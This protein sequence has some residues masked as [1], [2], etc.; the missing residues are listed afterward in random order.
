MNTAEKVPN[1]SSTFI[2]TYV[3]HVQV[4]CL[5]LAPQNLHA[6][7]S[8][9]ITTASLSS[10]SGASRFTEVQQQHKSSGIAARLATAAEVV[11]VA[12]KCNTCL[13]QKRAWQPLLGLNI[14]RFWDHLW[15]TTRV[16]N[17]Y[18]Q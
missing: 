15:L 3:L 17:S 18:C 4:H 12:W 16:P 1:F 5:S 7:W 11:E 6:I 2:S 13:N 10:L 14:T 9:M 8:M